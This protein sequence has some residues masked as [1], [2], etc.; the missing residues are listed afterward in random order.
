MK[1]FALFLFFT[2]SSFLTF[3]Q[4]IEGKVVDAT[5]NKPIE[6]VHVFVKGINR[7]T[8]TNEKGNYYLKFPYIVIK[9]DII[10]FSHIAY[11]ELEIP[12][13]SSKKNYKVYLK[14][15]LKKLE[16]IRISGERNLKKL[17]SY[18]KLSPMKSGVHSFG[19][20]LKD[21]KIY[22][23]GGDASYKQNDL[24]KILDYDDPNKPI[25]DFF[26]TGRNF[27]KESFSGDLQTYSIKNDTWFKSKL[28]FKK[29]AYH[30]LNYYN[31]KIFVLGGKNIAASGKFEYLDD[32]IEILN[33][34]TNTL[35]IDHTNPHQ[36]VSFA[37][38]TYK[39]NIIVLGGS[40]KKKRNGFKEYSNK[41]HLF[42]FN[43]G[44]WYQIASMP[45]AKE[46]KGV[47]IKDKIYLIGGFNKKPLASIE[48]F[49]LITQK[50]KKEGE[51]FYG[52]SE[53]AITHLNNVIYL[54]DDGKI[55]TYNILTKELNEY[56]IDL[57]LEASELYT[58]NNKL[59]I[60]GGLRSND[61][62]QFPS[63]GLFSIDISEFNNTKINY[64]KTF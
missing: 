24:K 63:K 8:L 16:E 35:E 17:I 4:Y 5:T 26:K 19:S 51:L 27:K 39:D 42:N 33:L 20:F 37:S 53:P 7:G 40:I 32:K 43:T 48:S 64:S 44:K 13:V 59:F 38:F 9:K 36:G 56:L 29:R 57:S 50:W 54:F 10:R 34:E 14:G 61:Y 12:Y 22:V 2:L 55:S 47:L 45:I 62:S 3:S 60:L 58:V 18:K 21:D 25:T 49:D 41:V 46:V 6:G 23:I 52:I 28:K 15:D 1:K 11:E 30:N 31:N